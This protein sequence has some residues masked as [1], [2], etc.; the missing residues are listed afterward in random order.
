[1]VSRY[2]KFLRR[3]KCL[4]REREKPESTI[5]H[6]HVLENE[7]APSLSQFGKN[8]S[9]GKALIRMEKILSANGV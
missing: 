4:K 6:L 8:E 3:L 9:G 1:M 7:Y 2:F 5:N